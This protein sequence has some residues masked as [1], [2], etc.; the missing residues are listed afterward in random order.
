MRHALLLLIATLT[1]AQDTDLALVLQAYA[2]GS[3]AS[4]ELYFQREGY[5]AAM[6]DPDVLAV[7]GD[8]A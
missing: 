7:I 2:S 3:L 4:E 8:T 6:T 1:T 5:G